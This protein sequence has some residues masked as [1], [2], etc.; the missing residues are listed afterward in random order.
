MA[1]YMYTTAGLQ[2]MKLVDN[3]EG[4][5]NRETKGSCDSLQF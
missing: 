3:T 1:I 2:F 5:L 4:I